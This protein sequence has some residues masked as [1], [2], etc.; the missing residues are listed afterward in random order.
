V[1]GIVVLTA[2]DQMGFT[3][4][5]LHDMM[6]A[7][8]VLAKP[9]MTVDQFLDWAVGRRGRYELLRGEVVAMSPETVDHARMKGVIY[10]V[11]WNAIHQKRLTCEVFPD[12][13]TVRIDADTAYEPDAM[14]YCGDMITGAA[15]EVPNP[16]ILVEVLSRSTQGVDLTTKLAGYF[17][18]PSVA[19]YLIVDPT[20]PSVIHHA[21]AA[22]DTILTRIVTEGMITLEPPGLEIALADLYGRS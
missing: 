19:H 12:G 22:G 2:C 5:T 11:L 7:M 10:R 18:L 6:S 9:R 1:P 16:M 13:M 3:W 8:N 4:P 21:R 20:Q 17:R 15:L 14:V